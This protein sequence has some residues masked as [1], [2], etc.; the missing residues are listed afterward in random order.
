MALPFQVVQRLNLESAVRLAGD[1][2]ALPVAALLEIF[3]KWSV[4]TD[5]VQ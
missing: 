4:R 1:S 2:A 5:A 3:A